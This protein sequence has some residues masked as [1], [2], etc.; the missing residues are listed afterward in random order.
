MSIGRWKDF[1]FYFHDLFKNLADLKYH[2]SLIHI[3]IAE[4]SVLIIWLFSISLFAL[5]LLNWVNSLCIKY[6]DF[7]LNKVYSLI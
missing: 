5:S 1:K 2:F 7:L 4:L 3:F 6:E